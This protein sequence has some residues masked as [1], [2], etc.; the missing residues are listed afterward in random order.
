ME[1]LNKYTKDCVIELENTFNT[2]MN[3]AF[4]LF[5]EQAF[6]KQSEIANKRKS[7]INRSLFEVWSVTLA[8]LSA[9]HYEQLKKRKE[10]LNNKFITLLKDTYFDEAITKGTNSPKKVKYRFGKIEQL[11]K[12]CI[13]D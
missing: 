6:R 5:G 12:E 9:E 11:V 10:Y 4:T 2:S 8:N 13:Y 1:K 7:P 3:R